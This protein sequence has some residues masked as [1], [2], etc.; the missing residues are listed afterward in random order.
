MKYYIK[1]LLTV[2]LVTTAS[3][4]IVPLAFADDGCDD[5]VK[6]SHISQ[7]K[8]KI[9]IEQA[10]RD[11]VSEY[12]NIHD[13]PLAMGWVGNASGEGAD[14]DIVAD[15]LEP[16]LRKH[17]KA[18]ATTDMVLINE[19]TVEKIV[20]EGWVLNHSYF[21]MLNSSGTKIGA[22]DPWRD[23]THRN[24]GPNDPNSWTWQTVTRG[25]LQLDK[26]SKAAEQNYVPADEDACA[27]ETDEN[28]IR[29]EEMDS[30]DVADEPDDNTNPESPYPEASIEY[31]ETNVEEDELER[32]NGSDEEMA[33]EEQAMTLYKV[34]TA[35]NT[36][37]LDSSGNKLTGLGVVTA[38]GLINCYSVTGQILNE[39]TCED[40]FEDGTQVTL[41]YTPYPGFELSSWD[42]SSG[43]ALSC[44]CTDQ[45]LTC[46]FEVS[47]D[48]NCIA[49]VKSTSVLNMSVMLINKPQESIVVKWT[50]QE[51]N[52]DSQDSDF[53][54]C[55]Y[56]VNSGVSMSIEAVNKTV[57]Y[58]YGPSGQHCPCEGSSENPC[59]FTLE[60]TSK[61][62]PIFSSNQV[63]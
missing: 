33:A 62:A 4:Q 5:P 50:D 46:S 19:I 21:I 59:T 3:T 54:S 17:V 30:E 7:A 23:F 57:A 41:E 32:D 13:E 28:P 25:D 61:C 27:S 39:G 12:E 35:L 45:A 20:L 37:V 24:F 38:A 15:R 31:D 56:T 44:P 47:Q 34:T 51:K 52:C 43:S 8:E 55:T 49:W 26:A 22:A 29:E 42:S 1:L 16:L 10:W 36:S 14:C 6:F 40:M 2:S 18:R 11:A 58:W 53:K 48:V 60:Q 9:L 63:P